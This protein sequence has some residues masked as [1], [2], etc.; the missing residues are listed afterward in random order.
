[1]V[2]ICFYGI[3]I[4]AP[5]L[6][7]PHVLTHSSP[8]P[9]DPGASTRK[10]AVTT[11]KAP[12]PPERSGM[13]SASQPRPWGMAPGGALGALGCPWVPL[14]ALACP[15]GMGLKHEASRYVQ[16]INIDKYWWPSPD[17]GLKSKCRAWYIFVRWIITDDWE[18]SHH[19]TS[20]GLTPWEH[21]PVH[22]M[23]LTKG[24]THHSSQ[25]IYIYIPPFNLGIVRA[26]LVSAFVQLFVYLQSIFA[27]LSRR[28]PMRSIHLQDMHTFHLPDEIGSRFNKLKYLKFSVSLTKS[29]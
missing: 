10:V 19:L 11:P 22:Q 25:R 18:N 23:L 4:G 5:S 9:G 13:V 17:M 24:T 16:V 14:C 7:N 12:R 15:G 29:Y 26:T 8:D 28:S 6:P 3:R 21:Q 27:I 20:C 2:F 1:M